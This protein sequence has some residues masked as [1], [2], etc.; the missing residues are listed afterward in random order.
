MTNNN[1]LSQKQLITI[2]GWPVEPV[3]PVGPAKIG[4][5]SDFIF[6]G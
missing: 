4:K 3:E 6:S 5:M 1:N 2:L